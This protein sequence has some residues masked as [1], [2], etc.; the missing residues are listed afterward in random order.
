MPVPEH[1]K[2]APVLLTG[3]DLYYSMFLDL[4]SCRV[5]G[6]PIPWTAMKDYCI[7][8]EFDDETTEEALHLVRAVDVAIIDHFEKKKPNKPKSK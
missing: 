7:A 8:Y 5:Q 1:I 4:Q 3:L 2:N 6:G